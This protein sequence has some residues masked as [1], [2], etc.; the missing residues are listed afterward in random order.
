MPAESQ[1]AAD[2]A[3]LYRALADHVRVSLADIG[4]V[5]AMLA[6][7]LPQTGLA[8]SLLMELQ[9]FDRVS[10]ALDDLVRMLEHLALRSGDGPHAAACHAEDVIAAAHLRSTRYTMMRRLAADGTDT[11]DNSALPDVKAVPPG[12]LDLL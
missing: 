9:S 11:P 3:R 7:H 5:E 2:A 4:R 8:D 1:S 10:Q 6:R 12:T